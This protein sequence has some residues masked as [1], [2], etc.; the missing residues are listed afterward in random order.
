[1]LETTAVFTLFC[2]QFIYGLIRIVH[3]YRFYCFCEI[4]TEQTTKNVTGKEIY[5]YVVKGNQLIGCVK[6]GVWS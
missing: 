4:Y 5:H 2:I 3:L 1:V 6:L